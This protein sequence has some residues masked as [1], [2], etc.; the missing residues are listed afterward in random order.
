MIRMLVILR[1]ILLR[2]VGLPGRGVNVAKFSQG[3]NVGAFV[4]SL[5]G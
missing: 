4:P 1:I 2:S 3:F 5:V